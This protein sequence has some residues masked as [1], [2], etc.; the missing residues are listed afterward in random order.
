MAWNLMG[1]NIDFAMLPW[2][3][4]HLGIDDMDAV[5]LDMIQIRDFQR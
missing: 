2:I 3:C 4:D 1:G 5:I